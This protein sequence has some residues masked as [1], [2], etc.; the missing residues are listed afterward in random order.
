VSDSPEGET[1]LAA[2]CSAATVPFVIIGSSIRCLAEDCRRIASCQAPG[3]GESVSVQW[4]SGAGEPEASAMLAC[5]GED[6]VITYRWR[7][8][9]RWRSCRQTIG[10]K[11][12]VPPLGGVRRFWRCPLCGGGARKLYDGGDGR[13]AC[14][15]CLRLAHRSQRQCTWQRALRRSM[16]IRSYLNGD[17]A[18]ADPFPPK[19]KR[20]RRAVY[21]ALKAEVERLESLPAEAWLGAGRNVALGVRR[22]TMGASKRRW[23]P[24]RNAASRAQHQ[25]WQR[26]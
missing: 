14:K 10:L 24:A 2:A 13:F 8:G 25:P 7:E 18:P 16:K 5:E 15:R 11:F 6:V 23:W 9:E 22:G 17:S 20:M 21:E 4:R 1:A 19:P 3:D 12:D 26:G